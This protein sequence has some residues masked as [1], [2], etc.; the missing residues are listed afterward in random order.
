MIRSIRIFL[1]GVVALSSALFQVET[2][3]AQQV[4]WSMGVTPI[5]DN[6]TRLDITAT[7]GDGW[8]I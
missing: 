2:L 3:S 5:E 7:I 6:L 1:A 4:G 8:H